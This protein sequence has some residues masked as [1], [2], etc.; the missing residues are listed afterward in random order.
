MSETGFE[1]V[2]AI[3]RSLNIV[4]FDVYSF[5]HSHLHPLQGSSSVPLRRKSATL[6]YRSIAATR[7]FGIAL[8]SRSLSAQGPSTGKLLRTFEMVAA[9]KPTSRLSAGPNFLSH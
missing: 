4:R 7:R 5:R 1:A 6:S 8:E 9:S 2:K 3:L